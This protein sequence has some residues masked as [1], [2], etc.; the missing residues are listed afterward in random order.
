[1]AW[2]KEPLIQKL[3]FSKLLT[4]KS[5]REVICRIIPA[6]PRP[7][8]FLSVSRH[9]NRQLSSRPPKQ[10]RKGPARCTKLRRDQEE[11]ERFCVV[12]ITVVACLL[13][14]SVQQGAVRHRRRGS[15]PRRA[16]APGAP[17]QGRAGSPAEFTP[18]PLGT[19]APG[20]VQS[21]GYLRAAV[22]A[23]GLLPE[24]AANAF[25]F[26]TA[27]CNRHSTVTFTL[28]RGASEV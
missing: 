17:G 7:V 8:G 1:M 27:L 9:R 18:Y 5:R 19:A 23:V 12:F 28:S 16:G 21:L 11:Q 14:G 20:A 4:L 22:R 6:E 24:P 3:S 25:L 13:H 10:Q 15:A 2:H 26:I